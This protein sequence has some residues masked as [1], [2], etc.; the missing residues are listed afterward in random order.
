MIPR[1][2]R[3]PSAPRSRRLAALLAGLAVVAAAAFGGPGPGV[4]AGPGARIAMGE[5]ATLDP[6]V[7]GDA[8]SAAV[9][10]QVFEGL[11]ALDPSLTP[12]PALAAGWELRDGGTTVAFTLRDGLTFSDGTPLTAADVRRSWLRVLDPAAPSPLSSLLYDVVGA[13]DYATG[14]GP[15][16]AVGIVANGTSLEVRLDRPAGDFPAVAASPTL[17]VVPPGVGTVP[18]ALQAG[19]GFVGSGGYLLVGTAADGLTLRANPRYWAGEPA[20]P[21]ITVVTDLGGRSPV[22]VFAGGEIDWVPVGTFDASW[23]AYDPDLGASLR[24]WTD[25]A[26]TYYGFETRRPPFSDARVRRAFAEAVDWS[27]I[28]DLVDG[29][30]ALPATSMV[31]PGIPGRSDERFLPAFDPAG[32]RRLLAAAGYADPATFPTVTLVTAGTAYDGAIIAQLK[33]N[34]GI[35]IRFEALDFATLFERLGSASSPDLWSVSWIADYPSPNDFLGILLG[36]GQPNN[37]GG[38]TSA[39]FD[40][41]IARA[42]GTTDAAAARAGYDAA[43]RIVADE[44]PVVPVSYG[45]SDAL[46]RDGLLGAAP[47]G[48][49]ILRLAGL[50]WA[51]Q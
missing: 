25:L 7:A 38:W 11:T 40:A 5:P 19:P 41:A 12:R 39:D 26:V 20:I 28:V 24:Q 3:R 43:E 21:E 34:L 23:I 44:V 17:A 50:A 45:I 42:V 32:A 33:A 10:A 31:P 35:T 29:S 46:S 15:A 18:G 37:Y 1:P 22:D 14:R 6:A 2:A 16:D 8:A 9:I 48:L 51:G 4:A 27:R 47:N 36:T 13:R 49:G 30:T